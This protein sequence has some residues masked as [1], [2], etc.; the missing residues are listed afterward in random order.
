[1]RFLFTSAIILS[2]YGDIRIDYYFDDA[3]ND[4]YYQWFYYDDYRSR[5]TLKEIP[6][7]ATI[8]KQ[9]FIG[10]SGNLLV[11]IWDVTAGISRGYLRII[12]L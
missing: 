2:A 6:A 1:M 3:V 12:D 4:L 5:H 11:V 10:Q 7:G 9:L 8:R